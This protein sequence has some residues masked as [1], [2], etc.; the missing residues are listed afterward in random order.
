MKP[1]CVSREVPI[2]KEKGPDGGGSARRWNSKVPPPNWHTRETQGRG[3][4]ISSARISHH[5]IGE[6]Q[7]RPVISRRRMEFGLEL[8]REKKRIDYARD[9]IGDVRATDGTTFTASS[10]K[11]IRLNKGR[12]E[13]S[14][15]MEIP[16]RRRCSLPTTNEK[17]KCQTRQE[18]SLP[19]NLRVPLAL[20]ANCIKSAPCFS[21]EIINTFLFLFLF[22]FVSTFSAA[23]S[24]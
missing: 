16:P 14:S 4:F 21:L 12:L 7:S 9:S 17:Q 23:S 19:W 8:D 3:N 6:L 20:T 1:A 18:L 24:R 22:C 11:T 15:I 2:S 5:K 13:F 10:R